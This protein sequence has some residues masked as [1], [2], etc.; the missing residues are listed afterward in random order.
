MDAMRKVLVVCAVAAVLWAASPCRGGETTKQYEFGKALLAR[1]WF[2]MAE[3]VFADLAESGQSADERIRGRLGGIEVLKERALRERSP[4]KK[5]EL[6]A[7]AIEAFRKFLESSDDEGALF[8]LAELLGAKGADFAAL[9]QKGG[10]KAPAHRREALGAYDEAIGLVRDLVI[11]LKKKA[12]KAGG[13]ENLPADE[14]D[15][16]QR[17]DFT[18]ADLWLA[19][20]DVFLEA[21][22]E[23]KER[24]AKALGLFS[25]YVWEWEE[26]LSSYLAYIRM[27]VCHFRLGQMER[28]LENTRVVTNLD[29]SQLPEPLRQPAQRLVV[30]ATFRSVQ[31]LVASKKYALALEEVENLRRR[32]PGIWGA[33]GPNR[34]DALRLQVE[35]AKAHMGLGGYAEA[36]R[37][38]MQVLSLPGGFT[39]EVARLLRECNARHPAAAVEVLLAEGEGALRSGENTRAVD[40]FQRALAKVAV[41]ESTRKLRARIWHRMGTAYG[42]QSRWFEAGLAFEEGLRVWGTSRTAGAEEE[43]WG[44]A[45]AYR[46]YSSFKTQHRISGSELLRG[47]FQA[48]LRRLTRDF[49][50]SPYATNLSF[51]AAGDLMNEGRFLEAVDLLEAVD[52]ASEYYPHA[53]ARLGRCHFKVFQQSR[54]GEAAA[55]ARKHLARSEEALRTYLAFAGKNPS[56]PEESRR[57]TQSDALVRYYLAR[58]LWEGSRTDE[59][60]EILDGFEETYRRMKGT[61]LSACFLKLRVHCRRR[62]AGDAERMVSEIRILAEPPEGEKPDPGARGTLLTALQM[63]GKLLSELATEEEKKS[64]GSE[65][66]VEYTAKAADAL[67]RAAE[68]DSRPTFDKVDAAGV[69]LFRAKEFS[70]AAGLYEKILSGLPGLSQEKRRE[71]ELKLAD[72]HIRKKDWARAEP[73]LTRLL[74]SSGNPVLREKLVLVLHRF[75]D[76]LRNQQKMAAAH[77]CYDRALKLYRKTLDRLEKG[78]RKWFGPKLAMWQVLFHKG[79][80]D[81]VVKQIHQVKSLYPDLGGPVSRGEILKLWARARELA[82]R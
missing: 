68:M 37:I 12:E 78:S 21:S 58:V 13:K 54:A 62:S 35:V 71:A 26:Y 64:S 11:R 67:L 31:V 39:P 29:L 74:G 55:P 82:G 34:R 48:A 4:V 47:R 42:L 45:C 3:T 49:A 23:R 9:A 59:V 16:Y 46:A 6:F 24:L 61:A 50:D 76:T 51:F 81:K 27:G 15:R 33:E 75:G 66:A 22:R 65:L 2:D 38:L 17:A 14:L 43:N 44:A 8:G 30:K 56:K 53:L 73:I 57:R 18:R 80:Y 63:L 70:K 60:L 7:L 5:R 28:A 25:D 20:A 40:A 19:S 32:F 1:G 72:C 41:G 79:K 36:V 52:P 77:R 69:W 10:E